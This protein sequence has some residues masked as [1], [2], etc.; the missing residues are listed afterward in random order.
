MTGMY[1]S[2]NTLP[3]GTREH[4]SILF[5]FPRVCLGCRFDV[6]KALLA[7]VMHHSRDAPDPSLFLFLF[8]FLSSAFGFP[9]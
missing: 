5:H 7:V 2:D 3:V 4:S 6:L 1:S 8:L 9:T